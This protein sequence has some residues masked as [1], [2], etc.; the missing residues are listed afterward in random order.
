MAIFRSLHGRLIILV[1]LA[2][3]PALAL[4]V[5]STWYTAHLQQ[6][7]AL[8]DTARLATLI[9]TQHERLIAS[10]LDLVRTMAEAEEIRDGDGAACGRYLRQVMATQSIYDGFA[11]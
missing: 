1:T 4:L 6:S 8:L 7:S 10:T 11:R 5:L 9:E 2:T 3:L